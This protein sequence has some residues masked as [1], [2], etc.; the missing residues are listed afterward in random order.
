MLTVGQ[1]SR[2]ANGRPAPLLPSTAQTRS[3]QR[4]TVFRIAVYPGLSVLNRPVA[5]TVSCSSTTSIVAESLW[6]STP[7]NTF[8]MPHHPKVLNQ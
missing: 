6:G 5:S 8:A 1:H 7:M 3:G 4:D 2:C